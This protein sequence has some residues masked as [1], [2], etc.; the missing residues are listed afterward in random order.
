MIFPVTMT[1]NSKCRSCG[2]WRLPDS[3]KDHSGATLLDRVTDDPF[4][5]EHVES[6]NLSG[7]E[8]F[9]HPDIMGLISRLLNSY[10][11]LREICINTDGHLKKEIKRTLDAVLPTCRDK[12]VVLRMYISLDGIGQAHDR[13]RRHRGAFAQAD[14]ALC[15]LAGMKNDWPDALRVSASFTITNRNID[16]IIPVFEYIRSLGVRVDYILAARPEVFIG[17]NGLERRFQVEGDQVEQVREAIRHICAHPENLNFS[18][19]FYSTM[20]ETLESRKRKRACFYPEKG[21]VLMPDGKVY[22]CGTY[23]DFY[24]G[25]LLEDD[26]GTLWEGSERRKRKDTLIPG[27]CESCFSNSY[28]DWDLASG[29]VV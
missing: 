26:F 3:S 2:I 27:K 25:N 29:A 14:E 9:I 11:R 17:G 16:Q 1:C 28:E 5:R 21:F 22:I 4:L 19:R 7:G 18:E 24:F 12:G 8:P 13:H 10:Q 6:I 15:Y 20:L 23:L